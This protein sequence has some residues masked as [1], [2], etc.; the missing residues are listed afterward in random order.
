[1]IMRALLENLNS[2]TINTSGSFRFRQGD[3]NIYWTKPEHKKFGESAPKSNLAMC[4]CCAIEIPHASPCSSPWPSS[5]T[6][7]PLPRLTRLLRTAPARP[8]PAPAGGL[9]SYPGK[10]LIFYIAVGEFLRNFM[11]LSRELLK[12][13]GYICIQH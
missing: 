13:S 1:V 10:L 6:S 5:P 4:N 12:T 2:R 9:G 7:P 8:L 3:H 11:V